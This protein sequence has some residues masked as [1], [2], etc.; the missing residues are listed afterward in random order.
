MQ[1]QK[2]LFIISVSAFRFQLCKTQ[3]IEKQIAIPNDCIIKFNEKLGKIVLTKSH[4]V[5]SRS[6]YKICL[7]NRFICMSVVPTEIGALYFHLLLFLFF[8]FV[9]S[10]L[11]FCNN[12]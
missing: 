8:L 12:K 9:F 3:T 6:S 1:G 11:L 4:L 5:L 7:A 2:T 10:I